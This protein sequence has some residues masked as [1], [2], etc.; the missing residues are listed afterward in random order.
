M[1]VDEFPTFVGEALLCTLCNYAS[2]NPQQQQQQLS[3]CILEFVEVVY[4]S[5]NGKLPLS[6]CVVSLI[7][8]L[9]EVL[10]YK[11]YHDDSRQ[12][13]LAKVLEALLRRIFHYHLVHQRFLIDVVS[14]FS[15]LISRTVYSNNKKKNNMLQ[16]EVGCAHICLV[17]FKLT[18]LE[19][20]SIAKHLSDP[21]KID[22]FFTVMMRMF[23]ALMIN[24]NNSNKDEEKGKE[25]EICICDQWYTVP[26][27]VISKFVDHLQSFINVLYKKK[28]FKEAKILQKDE[29]RLVSHLFVNDDDDD[30]DVDDDVDDDDEDDVEEQEQLEKKFRLNFSHCGVI[31]AKATTATTATTTT[32]TSTTSTTTTTSTKK[33]TKEK[34]PRKRKNFYSF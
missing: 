16:W 8:S 22:G 34:S 27:Q 11:L 26:F 21:E 25:K 19:T 14:I 5:E 7:V 6:P 17:F 4:N 9:I 15:S 2:R 31:P 29:F 32:T 12:N 3:S 10:D 28:G 33:R 20:K 23:I 30:D 24:N 1:I 18:S 13:G